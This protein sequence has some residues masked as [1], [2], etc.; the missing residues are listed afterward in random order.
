MSTTQRYDNVAMSLHWLSAVAVVALFGIGWVMTD[1]K[2]GSPLQFS[3]YQAHKSIGMTVLVLT[4]LRLGWR[5]FHRAPALPDQMPVWEQRLAHLGHFGLYGLLAAMPLVGW[6]IVSTSRFNLPTVLFGLIPLPHLTFL[7]EIGD[8]EFLHK[9]FEE[10]HEAGSL[11]ML[12]LLVAHVIAALRH[13][14]ILK[15][16]VLGRMVPFLSLLFF[17]APASSQAAEWTLDEG[18]SRLGFVGSQS[19][20]AFE[21]KFT[22]WTA[23]IDFDPANPTAGKALITIDM[24]SAATGDKQKDLSLPQPEWFDTKHFP[25]AIFEAKGFHPKG[26]SVFEAPGSLTIRGHGKEF[27]LPFTLDISGQTAHAKGRLDLIRTEYG[28]G[29]GEWST[30]QYVALEVAV[31]FDLYAVRKN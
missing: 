30:A 24:S 16:G 12:V 25:Q 8:R 4:I 28:V 9:A 5:A 27:V 2:P 1:L 3:L 7:M 6:A 26:G 21:G 31:T 15:D 23:K 17:L 13:Q 10:M 18:K 14:Y 19:G 20:A 29:Q 22:R 11:L